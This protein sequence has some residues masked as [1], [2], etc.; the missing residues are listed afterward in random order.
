MIEA[1]ADGVLGLDTVWGGLR[2]ETAEYHVHTQLAY[3][4]TTVPQYHGTYGTYGT[5]RTVG[6]YG[7]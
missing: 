7:P 3:H 6:R 5:Y 2:Y 4:G 1:A